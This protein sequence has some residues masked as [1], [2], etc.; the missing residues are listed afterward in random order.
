MKNSTKRKAP[1]VGTNVRVEEGGW[2]E[3]W[4]RKIVIVI[5]GCGVG[6]LNSLHVSSLFESDRHFSHLS[7]LEREMTFRTEMGLYYSYFKVLVHAESVGKG[8]H[9]LYSNNVTEFPLVINT[10]ERF[11]LYPELAAGLLYRALNSTG[12]LSQLCWTVNRGENLEP[13]LSCEGSQD[14]PHF[15]IFIVWV[16]AGLTTSLLFLLGLLLSGSILGGLLPVI[17]FFYNHGEA[18][19]VM[20]TPPLRESFAFPICLAQ[21]LV[22]SL[23]ARSASPGRAHFLAICSL[24][25]GFIVCWQFAQFMLFTQLCAVFATHVVGSLSRDSFL[26]ILKA[27]LTGL[28]VALVLMFGNKM[29]VTS[30]MFSCLVSALL[31]TLP[32]ESF[33][34][35]LSCIVRAAAQ[36]FLFFSLTFLTKVLI[37]R[38]FM[39]QDD[40]HVFDLL[41]SK[42]TDFRS[43]HTLLYTCAVEFDFL[44]WEMP[45]KT[46]QTLLL[47]SAVVASLLL[48]YTFISSLWAHWVQYSG[49][50][51][52]EAKDKDEQ[53]APV[54]PAA[55]YNLLQCM[56]YAVMA[57]LIMRL[58]L[59]FTP[60]LCLLT[61]LLAS[62]LVPQ[63]FPVTT[64]T[65]TAVLVALIAGM[66]VQGVVNLQE[67][68]QIMGEY[69]NPALE[70]LIDWINSKLPPTAVMG[71]PMPTMANLLLSTGRPIVNHPHYEDTGLRERTKQVYT[72][73]SRR[74]PTQ[75]H[76]AMQKLQVQYLV[77][78]SA[79]CLTTERDGCALTEVWD[80]EEPEL[81][82]KGA[83]PVC[84]KL[85]D[86]TPPP[87]RAVFQNNEY[88]VLKVAPRSQGT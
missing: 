31:V 62:P 32:L 63:L 30:W 46:S 54:D 69:Q 86:K 10:L 4:A 14:P 22:V 76:E 56:A 41:K 15:Y 71:G 37:T 36:I 5:V 81:A 2:K 66:S 45:Y 8:V 9:Q 67:Q 19:R 16:F 64:R 72:C 34:A 29:L 65:Q 49:G 17:A 60:H 25:T 6:Y 53:I 24:T 26:T 85:W 88:K 50:W 59:F 57:V 52:L 83:P 74:T 40:A 61:S 70:E 35:K 20:W 77:L 11:N 13:V 51:R 12:L 84:P 47:P 42:F 58:K 3:S 80:Q 27:N 1:G 44:G 78:S 18:T 33:L 87:F 43:F 7:N 82:L 73:F 38:L 48:I 21:I 39:I 75:V 79:W 68:R 23:T 28:M 55:L